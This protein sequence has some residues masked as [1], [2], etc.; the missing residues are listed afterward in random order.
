ML[1]SIIL[2]ALFASQI[3]AKPL[4]EEEDF[5]VESRKLKQNYVL[6]GYVRNFKRNMVELLRTKYNFLNIAESKQAQ[7]LLEQF[8]RKFVSDLNQ[9]LA[10]TEAG[11]RYSKKEIS[12]GMGDSTFRIVKYRIRSEFPRLGSNAADELVYRFRRSIMLIRLK[13]DQ[14]VNDAKLAWLKQAKVSA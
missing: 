10:E 4:Q 2:V 11:K 1:R 6:V 14:L 9:V 8:E 3:A 13:L 7:L 12:D 5:G